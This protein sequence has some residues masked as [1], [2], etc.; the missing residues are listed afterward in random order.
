MA[1]LTIRTKLLDKT[2]EG[3]RVIDMG[4]GL[5]ECFVLPRNR[6][7][8]VGRQ[9][10]HLKQYG[11]YILLGLDKRMQP[12][13]YIGQT[14]DFTNRVNVHKQEKDFWDTALVFVSKTDEIFS[15]EA[16]YLEYLGWKAATEAGNYLIENAKIIYEPQLSEDK[17]D[18]MDAFFENIKLLTRFYGCKIF[19][20]PEKT[21][22]EEDGMEFTFALPQSGM[23]ATLLF[24][25]KSKRY[26]IVAGSTI[27]AKTTEGC[28]KGMQDFRKQIINNSKQSQQKGE[29]CLLLKDIEIPETSCSPSGAASFCAGTSRRGTEDWR[30]KDGNKYSAEWWKE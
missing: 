27:V 13:A 21:T 29:L 8:E 25:K 5:C 10:E 9:Q 15:S 28:S 24:F 22:T 26:V 3:A 1:I 12:M 17:K 16:L 14:N 6:V 2:L 7:A 18:E 20:K 4:T 11:C 19:D 23:E 30:D